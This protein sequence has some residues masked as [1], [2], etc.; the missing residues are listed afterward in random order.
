MKNGRDVVWENNDYMIS[1]NDPKN[2][3]YIA[4]WNNGK[5]VGELFTTKGR[6]AQTKDIWVFKM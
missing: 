6:N 4:L 2:A 3:T 5:K 1:V